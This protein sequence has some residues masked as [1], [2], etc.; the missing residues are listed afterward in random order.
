MAAR[1]YGV[2]R[3]R[4]YCN[5]GNGKRRLAVQIGLLQDL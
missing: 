1:K 2:L 4:P 3:A 5:D